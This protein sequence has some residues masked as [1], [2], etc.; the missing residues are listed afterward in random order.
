MS[1]YLGKFFLFSNL[2][3]SAKVNIIILTSR[4]SLLFLTDID[5][6]IFHYIS[7]VIWFL[8][9]ISQICL[10]S[11]MLFAYLLFIKD[12]LSAEFLFSGSFSMWQREADMTATKPL[13]NTNYG[14][15]YIFETK[16]SLP[17]Y[18][19]SKTYNTTKLC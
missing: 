4:Q 15:I 16:A 12:I 18:P 7:G 11:I 6:I 14:A 2:G 1:T 9:F 19:S 17:A 8:V 13:S 10:E 5:F 3:R